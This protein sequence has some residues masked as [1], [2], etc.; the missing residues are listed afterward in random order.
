MPSV[1]ADSKDN[2]SILFIRKIIIKNFIMAYIKK[3]LEDVINGV[4][5]FSNY[6]LCY[7]DSIS[8]TEWGVHPDDKEEYE[9]YTYEDFKQTPWLRDKFRFGDWDNPEYNKETSTHYA[10]FTPKDLDEQWGD[11]WNDAPY[12]HNAGWPYDSVIVE[13]NENNVATEIEEYD[14]LQV[15]FALKSYNYNL[16]SGDFLNSPWAVDD[17]NAGAVAWIYDVA[18]IEDGLDYKGRKNYKKVRTVIKAGVNPIQFKE[19]VDRINELNKD[20]WNAAQDED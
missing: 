7:I 5:D 20:A 4:I 9:K 16:P 6:K 15:S 17:I 12:E 10:F 13:V 2:V 8:Q 11:D 19:Y 14:I 3:K 18:Y 1:V